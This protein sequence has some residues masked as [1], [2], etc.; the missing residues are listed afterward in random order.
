[1]KSIIY[2]GMDVHK[3]SFTLSYF[4]VT[5]QETFATVKI[6][7]DAKAIKKYFDGVSLSRSEEC[8]FVCGYE[9]GCL[10]YTLYHQ[11][12]AM[13]IRCVIMAPTTMLHTLASSLVSIA[14]LKTRIV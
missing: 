3:A 6:S 2:V 7:P 10:G 11:L 4:S 8:E 5:T 9:A 1:M 12:T 14:V 13:N